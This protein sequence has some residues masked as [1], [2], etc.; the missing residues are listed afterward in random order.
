LSLS[1]RRLLRLADEG[2]P[3]SRAFPRMN[4]GEDAYNISDVGFMNLIETLSST[5]PPLVQVVDRSIGLTVE[6]RE[7]L[8][9]RKDRVS[10]GMD[11]WMGGVH[12]KTGATLIWRWG[13]RGL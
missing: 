1:E 4:D 9:G 12:L 2:L 8:A 13:G 10:Y 6:G 3:F 5:S 11:R 7:V